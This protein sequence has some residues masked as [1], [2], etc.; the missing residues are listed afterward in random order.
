MHTFYTRKGSYSVTNT[1]SLMLMMRWG[2]QYIVAVPT[3]RPTLC[4]I[5]LVCAAPARGC[6]HYFARN[7]H[8]ASRLKLASDVNMR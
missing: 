6:S 4:D 3:H 8:A 1:P 2:E 7:A 5:S